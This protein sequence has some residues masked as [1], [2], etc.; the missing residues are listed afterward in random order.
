[1]ADVGAVVHLA[2]D[3][4]KTA[5]WDS[6]LRNNIDGTQVV[7]SAAAAAG[8]DRFAFASS[9]HPVGGYETAARPP[10]L[11]RTDDQYPP[12]GAEPPRPGT[13]YAASTATARLP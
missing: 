9:N 13:L 12:T 5:P 11:Y 10:E 3:P 1:M 8:V 6:V 7:L 4:R 2:G